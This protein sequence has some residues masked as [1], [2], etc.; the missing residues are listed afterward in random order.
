M[1]D[2]KWVST[3]FPSLVNWQWP[4]ISN[5]KA[6]TRLNRKGADKLAGSAVSN[7]NVEGSVHVT[8]IPSSDKIISFIFF[9]Y[10]LY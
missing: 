10:K 3:H 6:A 2:E 5:P 9:S 1:R 8:Y 4:L 7:T